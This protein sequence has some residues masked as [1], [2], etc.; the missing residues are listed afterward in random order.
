MVTDVV[1]QI[2][3]DISSK[4]GAQDPPLDGT[5]EEQQIYVKVR[6]RRRHDPVAS[7]RGHGELLKTA[8]DTLKGR[9]T[10]GVGVP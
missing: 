9:F 3:A 8:S 7:I 5:L 4:N 2:V 6:A 10:S 1:T